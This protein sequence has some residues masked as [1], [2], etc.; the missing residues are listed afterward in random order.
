MLTPRPAAREEPIVSRKR[1]APPL[2][3]RVNRPVS[4]LAEEQGIV[5]VEPVA[6]D[7]HVVRH[8]EDVGVLLV[9]DE[10][11][12]RLGARAL[13]RL[14]LAAE[15]LMQILEQ[16][17]LPRVGRVVL[18]DPLLPFAQ[19]LGEGLLL[20]DLQGVQLA[21]RRDHRAVGQ[22][23]LELSA[24]LLVHSLHFHLLDPDHVAV[25]LR[26]RDNARA[27]LL[28]RVRLKLQLGEVGLEPRLGVVVNAFL[29]QVLRLQLLELGAQ[30]AQVFDLR[31]ESVL[32]RLDLCVDL[33]DDL[34]DVLERL[35][36][37]L[38]HLR[39]LL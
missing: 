8:T 12:I 9:G 25:A 29:L 5:S 33:L 24:T 15:Q 31:G 32:A 26:L 22:L 4:S 6:S 2:A 16:H 34:R 10:H 37:H 14:H 36:L 38:V 3:L 18:L 11:I 30:R 17:H 1:E 39:L 7:R 27:L 19:L 21:V 23:P 13:L 20:L 35:A 28:R